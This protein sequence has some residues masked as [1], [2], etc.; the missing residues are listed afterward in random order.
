MKEIW[1]I[2]TGRFGLIA[3]ERLSKTHTQHHF[4]LV[5]PVRKNLLQGAGPNR[6]LE[7]MDGVS[8]L[9][10]R[11]ERSERPDWIIPALPIHLAAKWCLVKQS[12]KGLAQITIPS[13]LDRQVP[14]PVRD[15]SG[16]LYVSHAD[17]LCP[18]DCDEPADMC[19]VTQE[20][21]NM[22][23]FELLG[24][25]QIPT[26]QSI[27]VRSYQLCPGIGGYRPRQLFNLLKQV[28]TIEEDFLLSTACRCHGVITGLGY[29]Y[30]NYG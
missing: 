27:V 7:L 29:R 12:A 23:M 3:A 15:P 20:R 16:N 14:N 5:D 13:E 24:K 21:R 18:D 22:N 11:L 2:G 6:A 9:D 8:F 30:Q 25:I 10:Q 19:T 26:F 28:E 17:F 4:V 1:I